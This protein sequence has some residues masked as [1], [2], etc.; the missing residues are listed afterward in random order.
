MA[1]GLTSNLAGF[2]RN[3]MSTV[4]K[5]FLDDIKHCSLSQ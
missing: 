5:S 3:L 1:P 2:Q 4:G